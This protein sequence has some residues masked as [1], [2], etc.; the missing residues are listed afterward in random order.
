MQRLKNFNQL[1][2]YLQLVLITKLIHEVVLVEKGCKVRKWIGHRNRLKW[3]VRSVS[4]TRWRNQIVL[5][6][7]RSGIQVRVIFR[8]HVQLN[9]AIDEVW[10]LNLCHRHR[11]FTKRVHGH[12]EVDVI[13]GSFII[14]H[15]V[16]PFHLQLRHVVLHLQLR[17]WQFSNWCAAYGS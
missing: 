12:V 14:S 4:W 16:S 3:R 7:D 11:K 9:R 6:F 1:L 13:V 15:Q 8:L 5:H 10:M 17:F 2:L